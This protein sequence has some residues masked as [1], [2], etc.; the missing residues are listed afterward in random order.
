MCGAETV[1]SPVRGSRPT[2]KAATSGPPPILVKD[3]SVNER[4]TATP[5][6]NAPGAANSTAPATSCWCDWW[7]WLHVIALTGRPWADRTPLPRPSVST[8]TL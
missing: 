2:P 4:T 8:D 5:V 6:S 7:P 1:P 3:T